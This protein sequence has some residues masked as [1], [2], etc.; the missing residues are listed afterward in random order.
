LNG[1]SCTTAGGVAGAITVKIASD[2]TVTLICNGLSTNPN[3]THSNGEGQNYTDC[4][5]PLGDPTTGTGYNQT[6][7]EDAAQAYPGVQFG[8]IVTTS[9]NDG[10]TGSA[11]EEIIAQGGTQEKVLLWQYSGLNTGHAAADDVNT[12]QPTYI[13]PGSGDPTWN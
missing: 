2:N 3:C 7:A 13:C 1:I 5:D 11:A 9:C 6:M 8:G 4:N 10:T 12:S